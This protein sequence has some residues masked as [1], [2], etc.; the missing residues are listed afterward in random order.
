MAVKSLC[1]IEGCSKPHYGRGLCQNHYQH[2]RSK[3]GAICSVDGC[4]N[5]VVGRGWCRSHYLRWRRH[6]DPQGGGKSLSE[7]GAPLEW[8]ERHITHGGKDCLIWPFARTGSGYGALV[9]NGI[10]HLAHR[11]MCQAV[12]GPAPDGCEA[13]HSCGNGHLACVNPKH[14]RWATKVENADDRTQHGR[15]SR[16]VKHFRAVLTEE[17]ALEIYAIR[18]TGASLKEVSDKYGINSATVFCIWDGQTWAWL[19]GARNGKNMSHPRRRV[20]HME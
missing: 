16:G 15:T 14:L 11:W 19:T 10:R 18:N 9:E 4:D 3:N 20:M 2:W 8:A 5:R 1:K 13:A 7:A 6:G 17:Q 12:N